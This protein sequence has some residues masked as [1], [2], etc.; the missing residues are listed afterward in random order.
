[1]PLDPIL[2]MGGSGAIGRQTAQ[3]LRAAY[4][5]LPLLIGGRDLAKAQSTAKEIG[6]AEGVV[7]DPARDDLGLHA[8]AQRCGGRARL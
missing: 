6:G 3:S 5:D 7:I 4:P 2:L 1:M 8:H